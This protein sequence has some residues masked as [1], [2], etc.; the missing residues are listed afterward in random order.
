MKT[1]DGSKRIAPWTR[2]WTDVLIGLGLFCVGLATRWPFRLTTLE[3]YDSANYALAVRKIDLLNH[4]PHPPGY[5]FL[6]LAARVIHF[7]TSD[8]VQ[9]LSTVSA[10]SGALS[11][12]LYFGILHPWLGR[13][14]ALLATLV[15]LFSAQVWFQ[16]VRPMGDALAFLVLLIILG[17]FLRC[18][19]GATR[20]WALG[21]TFLGVGMGVK[22]LLPFFL[23]GLIA[24]TGLHL[25]RR[26]AWS[27]IG[28]GVLGFGVGTLTWIVPWSVHTGS[29]RTYVEA[30]L[31]Q[32]KWQQETEALLFNWSEAGLRQRWSATFIGIWGGRDLAPFMGVLTLV[33]AWDVI[34]RRASLHWILW[35]LGPLIA[36]RLLIL[37]NWPR[38]SIYYLPFLTLLSLLGWARLGHGIIRLVGT[39]NRAEAS[40]G[41]GFSTVLVALWMALQ[42]IYILPI[43]QGFRRQPLPIVQVTGFIREHYDEKTTAILTDHALLGRYLDYYMSGSAIRLV[44]EPYFSPDVLEGVQHVLR[45]QTTY[46]PPLVSRRVADAHLRLPR[47]RALWPYSDLL[48]L[49]V[50]EFTNPIVVLTDWH[51]PEDDRS[52]YS[53]WAYP[54]GSRIWV[55]RLPSQGVTLHVQGWVP[56]LPGRPPC[57]IRWSLNG[58]PLPMTSAERVSATLDLDPARIG[59]PH[60]LLEVQPGYEFIP[61]EVFPDSS[62]RR[63]LG[64]FFLQSIEVLPPPP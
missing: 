32:A 55:L 35:L 14:P 5:L 20:A 51:T 48:N 42:T 28:L 15:Y 2:P 7:W 49:Y 18:L 58:Q 44:Y 59:Q 36:F 62:D 31:S 60:A 40:A 11:G 12:P 41:V 24:Y 54:Q 16:H 47:W 53:R 57:P 45:L 27:L 63:P 23:S 21:M 25:V 22:H 4:Q 39:P 10:L 38:F 34:R 46:V 26:K 37:G 50:F 19:N 9:A 43:L 1:H 61:A 29:V 13:L 56:R 33:G 30:A 17:L 64:C 6:I 52:P 8:P 3:E